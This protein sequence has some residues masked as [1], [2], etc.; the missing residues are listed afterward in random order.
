MTMKPTAP[1]TNESEPSAVPRSGG[2]QKLHGLFYQ[3]SHNFFLSMPVNLSLSG[4]QQS[5]A[6]DAGKRKGVQLE[7]MT[8]V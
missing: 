6:T 1:G 8:D 4:L 2:L 3:R 5:F 7:I